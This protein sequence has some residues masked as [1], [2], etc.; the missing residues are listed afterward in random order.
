MNTDK[1]DE[2]VVLLHQLGG[3][4]NYLPNPGNAG[5][6]LIAC[7]TYQFFERNNIE[8]TCCTSEKN[9]SD[10][11]ILVY[12]G[13][14]NFGGEN[15]RVGY[16]IKKYA[17]RV[18]AFVLL[19][20]TLFGAEALLKSLPETVH[21]F[22]RERVSYDYASKMVTDAKV[23]LKDDMVLSADV[24]KMLSPPAS[25]SALGSVCAELTRRVL[26][27]NEDFGISLKHYL[28]Y[29]IKSLFGHLYPSKAQDGELNAF[30]IDVE[31]TDIPIPHDN[32]DVSAL[33]ELSSCE[34]NLAKL[35]TFRFLSHINAFDTVNTNRLHVAIAATK[36]G[37]KV[38]LYGNNYFKIRAIY[39]FSLK[40][41]YPNVV[42]KD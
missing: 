30:R 37:K 1:N 13:G 7:A 6:S 15:S 27:K 31:K 12:G 2:L 3:K 11:D 21:L 34:P 19:P 41:K 8:Y 23:Y 40:G 14:G 42:W 36:L 38:N 39:E 22:C 18:K 35:S 17:S 9:I 26:F 32:I 29:T 10:G 5:D 28:S 24:S 20:H 4:I 33:Y 25:Q 16:Y